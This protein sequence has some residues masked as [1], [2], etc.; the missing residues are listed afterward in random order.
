MAEEENISSQKQDV[1]AMPIKNWIML[2]LANKKNVI[3]HD[4][5]SIMMEAFILSK[6]VVPSLETKFDFKSTAYGPFS[7]K[8][9]STIP[10]LLSTKMI[11]VKADNKA[12]YGG[13]GFI[14]T[15]AGEEKAKKLDHKLP[16]ELRQRMQLL[17]S[18][19]RVMGLTG[20]T[21]FIYSNYPE[22]LFLPKGD[23]DHV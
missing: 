11:K 9:A 22:Y 17:K 20:M 15:E 21:Q 16:V 8:V 3:A 13:F 10:Q 19:T 14:L 2:L 12:I 1:H 5:H 4:V 18:A 6:E 23:R 7:H